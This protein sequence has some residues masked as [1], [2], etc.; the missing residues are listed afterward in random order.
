MQWLAYERLKSGCLENF[1]KLQRATVALVGGKAEYEQSET[2]KLFSDMNESYRH[3]HS[4]D[5]RVKQRL[6]S[7]MQRV[8]GQHHEYTV[9]VT[10]HLG[11]SLVYCD[12]SEEALPFL[13]SLLTK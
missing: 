4:Y 7:W 6:L 1:L 11:Y 5:D 10:V 12:Q 3:G 9:R 2:L 8:H 13:E